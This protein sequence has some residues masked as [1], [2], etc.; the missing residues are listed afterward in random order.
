MTSFVFYMMG[1]LSFLIVKKNPNKTTKNP[2]QKKPKQKTKIKQKTH[3]PLDLCVIASYW[4]SS[5]GSY[6]QRALTEMLT[7]P[8]MHAC[9]KS[10]ICMIPPQQN[11]II[12]A[13]S[14]RHVKQQHCT[15]KQEKKEDRLFYVGFTVRSRT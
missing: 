14:K 2:M 13:A 9:Y 6:S 1:W 12:C 15:Y 7:N 3:M 5:L 8:Y 10:C 11:W 4:G